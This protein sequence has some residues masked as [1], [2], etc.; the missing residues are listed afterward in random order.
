MFPTGQEH[1][2]A[3]GYGLAGTQ[4]RHDGGPYLA[5]P[6]P[7]GRNFAMVGR[8]C[9]ISGGFGAPLHQHMAPVADMGFR[10][11]PGIQP[12]ASNHRTPSGSGGSM[13]AAAYQ[14]QPNGMPGPIVS[15]VSTPTVQQS[16]FD[17]QCFLREFRAF[18]QK[19]EQKLS[20]GYKDIS[21]KWDGVVET[22]QATNNA[23]QPEN[24]P[25]IR[26]VDKKVEDLIGATL[27]IGE[28]VDTLVMSQKAQLLSESP[29]HLSLESISPRS[30]VNTVSERAC[31]PSHGRKSCQ[32]EEADRTHKLE[33]EIDTLNRT[34][35]ALRGEVDDLSNTAEVVPKRQAV[36]RCSA[37]S[38]CQAWKT[39]AAR[40]SLQVT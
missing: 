20:K 23:K 2:P 24:S 5:M 28:Q 35:I 29:V 14:Y 6:R 12:R 39:D 21:A 4:V 18:E 37:R 31:P 8:Q 9:D 1:Y 30:A 3:P 13:P 19:W 26:S 27:H 33:R 17:S 10:S 32:E 22:I 7:M 25:T 38:G 34:I 16:S 36:V 40:P 15:S 11:H